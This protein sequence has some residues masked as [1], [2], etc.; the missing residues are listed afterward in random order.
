MDKNEQ[1]RENI[2]KQPR[3]YIYPCQICDFKTHLTTKLDE[4]LLKE[5]GISKVCKF[6]CHLCDYNTDKKCVFQRH[7]LDKHT[8]NLKEK[9][10][11]HL[12]DYN[13]VPNKIT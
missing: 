13:I 3:K 7:I 1:L 6:E 2:E 4:H 12:C 5:H 10:T 9:F 8:P 11:C